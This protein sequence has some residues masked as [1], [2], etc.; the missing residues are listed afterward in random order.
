[1]HSEIIVGDKILEIRKNGSRHF[2]GDKETACDG[3]VVIVKGKRYEVTDAFP[4]L[5]TRNGDYVTN[6]KLNS[7]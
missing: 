6:C 5:L 4:E 7:S 3:D 2:I 1:L